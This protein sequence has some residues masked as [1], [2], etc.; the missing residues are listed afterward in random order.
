MNLEHYIE[1]LKMLVNVDCGTQTPDGVTTVAGIMASVEP[2]WKSPLWPRR[3]GYE[4]W[5]A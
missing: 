2:G 5:A 3:G 4:K 1:E